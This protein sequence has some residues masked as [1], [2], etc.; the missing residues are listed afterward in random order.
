MSKR[1]TA[2][3]ATKQQQESPPKRK[4]V[5]RID[6]VVPGKTSVAARIS[7]E[8]AAAVRDA[9]QM[10]GEVLSDFVRRPVEQRVREVFAT[11]GRPC[12]LPEE[13]SLPSA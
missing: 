10:T 5:G 11:A 2:R 4:P 9:A 7:P 13:A 8:L 6:L 1:A 12:P 3:K